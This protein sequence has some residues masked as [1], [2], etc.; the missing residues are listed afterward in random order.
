M[1]MADR[2]HKWVEWSEEDQVHAADVVFRGAGRP[3][4]LGILRSSTAPA[5]SASAGIAR[6][7]LRA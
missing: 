6:G 2:Y 7:L 1:K 4:D 5:G 3:E